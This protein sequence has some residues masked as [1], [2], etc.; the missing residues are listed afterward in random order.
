M[1]DRDSGKG[2]EQIV[3]EKDVGEFGVEKVLS[4]V[5][6]KKVLDISGV[7]KWVKLLWL[8]LEVSIKEK[9]LERCV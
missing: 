2:V 4:K 6:S 7:K 9:V 5:I 8:L 1:W 3:C